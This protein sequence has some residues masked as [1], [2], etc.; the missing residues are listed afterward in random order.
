MGI[1]EAPIPGGRPLPLCGVTAPREVGIIPLAAAIIPLDVVTPPRVADVAT[2]PLV[3]VGI[4]LVGAPLIPGDPRVAVIPLTA[5]RVGVTPRPRA[6]TGDPRA[7]LIA[8]GA[9]RPLE[10]TIPPLT[11]LTGDPLTE[12]GDIDLVGVTAGDLLIGAVFMG[13]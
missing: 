12:A 11:P 5:P 6:I 1:L 4:P 7:P 9:P 10:A 2:L 8:V 3:A 13:L